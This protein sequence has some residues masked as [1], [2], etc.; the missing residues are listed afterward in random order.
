MFYTTLHDHT[1]GYTHP[2]DNIRLCKVTHLL[3]DCGGIL[4]SLIALFD[5]EIDVILSIIV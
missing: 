1:R 2:L 3:L 4:L 5:M